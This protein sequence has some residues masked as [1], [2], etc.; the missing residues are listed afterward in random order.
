[1]ADHKFTLEEI[2]NEYSADGKRSGI[3][4]T[5]EQPLSRG[6][7]E[8]EKLVNAATSERPLS[9]ERAGYD[10]VAP[11]PENTEELVDIKSTISHIKASKA[12]Q[13]AQEADAAPVLR[14]R[15]PT[16]HLRRENVSF[17]NAAGAGR[18]QASYTETGDSGYDGAVKLMEEDT[19]APQRHR[20]NVRQ[21]EDSTRAREKKKK[22]RRNVPDSAYLKES[23][24]GE[25]Q[26][27]EP[28]GTDEEPPVSRRHWEEEQDYYYQGS[29]QTSRF[30][31]V[32][33]R[34]RS[35][36]FGA[37]AEKRQP[38]NLE[39]VKKTLEN[40][41]NVVFFR[42]IAV[43]V[44]TVAGAVLA[45]TEVLGNGALTALVTPRGYGII[46][47]A[48]GL[49]GLG[50]MFPTVKNGLWNLLRFHADS[51]SMA[52][53]P[54]VPA[55]LG[56]VCVVISP[57][58]LAM[59]TV[60][61]YVPCALLALFCNII[62]RLLMVRRALRNVNVISREGQKRVLSYVSQEETAELLTRGVLHDIP[63]VT[64]VRKADG[65]CDILRYS[66]S[67]DMADG[68]CRTMTPICGIVTLLIAVGMT[69]IRMGTAVGMPWISFLVL[70]AGT[71]PDGKLLHCQCTGGQSAAGTESRRAAAS[72][73]A[74]LGYQSVDDFFDT[75]ALLVE[76]NDLF[77]KGSV[78][79][80]GMKVF[81]GAKVDD[82]LLDAAS[83]VHHGDSML[84]GAFAEMIPD[85]GTLLPVDEF[86]C[87]DGQGFCGW[88]ANQ[89]VLFGSREMMA[90]HNIE[91]LPTKTREAELAEG[92][93]D[94]LY[95]SVSGML[96]ALFSIRITADP[97]VKR[98][99]QAL[100]QERVALILRSVDC[101]VSLRRL[102]ALFDFP[103]SY[104][105]IIPTSMH[106]LFQRETGGLGCVS[107]SMTVGDSGF[108]AGA[109]LLG[110]RRVR[111]AAVIGVILLVVAGLLGLSLAMI[112]VVTGAYEKMTA[113][114]FLIYHVILTVVTALAVRLR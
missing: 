102:S 2:L 89:R 36:T 107:A 49:L 14:E 45:C 44:L 33:Q 85:V 53:L 34:V 46:Q 37:D 68:L 11:P 21:M 38:D 97:H 58:V 93:G 104:L 30:R 86:V 62:G 50:V 74:M 66:Y 39:L 112:H 12:A 101:S 87:E 10:T 59:D 84:Q 72:N 61:L 108:G 18:Y 80:E 28:V 60:H 100:R 96:A 20:P 81:S 41:R 4:H 9:R 55:L 13:A 69:L 76:A 32:R 78:Q 65:L 16:Q 79:I 103:E 88:I 94:V 110:A 105:K 27:A 71:A 24:T 82:V 52:V 91:G 51:D 92:N 111:R 43:L 63:I 31:P 83:L 64:A 25:F 99:M 54:L 40:L 22:R 114:F 113:Y 7:L 3:R 57:D 17:V 77:P 75:N 15:F 26:R 23:V 56:A 95:L 109:L 42:F 5:S 70:H 90:N 67:T 106:H 6:T 1:M 35:H 29:Q 48:L 8:T 47:L 98:Q 73:S 19:A